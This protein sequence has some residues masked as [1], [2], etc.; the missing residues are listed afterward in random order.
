MGKDISVVVQRR[1]GDE[2]ADIPVVDNDGRWTGR[3]RDAWWLL[4]GYSNGQKRSMPLTE[5]FE[6]APPEEIPDWFVPDPDE[7]RF[8]VRRGLPEGFETNGGGIRRGY[9][10]EWFGCYHGD[11]FMGDGAHSWLTHAELLA[12]S[13]VQ[14]HTLIGSWLREL[15]RLQLGDPEQ[16]RVVFGF[17]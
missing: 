8:P 12:A 17:D 2:W 4:G 5:L 6:D 13:E 15:E 1:D 11:V 16:V 10:E 9:P 14:R 3:D 7:P